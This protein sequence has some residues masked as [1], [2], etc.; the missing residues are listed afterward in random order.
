MPRITLPDGG[1]R[2]YDS[3]VSAAEVA[4]D[5]GPRLAGDALGARID[6][7]L[8]DLSNVMDRDAWL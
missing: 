5:I 8:S 3:P 2:T 7:E 6:G 4:A 1:V